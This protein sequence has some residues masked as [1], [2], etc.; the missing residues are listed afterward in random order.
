[1]D[2][3]DVQ[4]GDSVFIDTDFPCARVTSITLL[5]FNWEDG[6][7][8]GGWEP[9]EGRDGKVRWHVLPRTSCHTLIPSKNQPSTA[10]DA[11]DADSPGK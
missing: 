6:R 5:G 2:K 9:F 10:D 7:D 8:A 11:N 1:M 4:P 3:P